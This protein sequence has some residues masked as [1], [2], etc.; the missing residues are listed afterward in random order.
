M[1]LVADS[2][3]ASQAA[4]KRDLLE[5]RQWKEKQ[6]NP[7][8]TYLR[9][10]RQP[11]GASDDFWMA[12]NRRRAKK[13][14]PKGS[15]KDEGEPAADAEAGDVLGPD[16]TSADRPVAAMAATPSEM[17]SLLTTQR[18]AQSPAVSPLPPIAAKRAPRP[19]TPTV[20]P[21]FRF[22]M[23]DLET[24]IETEFDLSGVRD[25]TSL[26]LDLMRQQARE[27]SNGRYSHMISRW[28]AW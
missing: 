17:R 7:P 26:M 27:P 19:K 25:S 9:Y 20:R 10:S 14:P 22:T 11:K 23:N 16:D 28:M 24:A 4:H 8:R 3:V 6:R 13:A 2:V 12:G 21:D 18:S 5:A 15:E 1:E